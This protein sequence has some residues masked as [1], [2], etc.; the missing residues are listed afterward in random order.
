MLFKN[1]KDKH[2]KN[3]SQSNMTP[4]NKIA[5]LP[6]IS[7]KLERDAFFDAIDQSQ[8]HGHTVK[9]EA[10][11]DLS[12]QVTID[13]KYSFKMPKLDSKSYTNAQYFITDHLI[14]KNGS[15]LEQTGLSLQERAAQEIA[16]VLAQNSQ[17]LAHMNH[18]SRE[19][20]Q[21][22]EQ[23]V[24]YAIQSVTDSKA[25]KVN[26]IGIDRVHLAEP[27]FPGMNLTDGSVSFFLGKDL[28][29]IIYTR[30]LLEQM[31][32]QSSDFDRER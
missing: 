2:V 23:C 10:F 25:T 13:D 30:P 20:Y 19:F 15:A 27:L 11:P 5:K 26:V 22:Y 7:E 6:V 32:N 12:A 24:E 29:Q 9:Y 16:R 1:K 28:I 4:S 17:R 3:T 18:K 8:K 21:A 14:E 31:K